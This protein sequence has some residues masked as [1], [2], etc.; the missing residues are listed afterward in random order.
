M[1]SAFA[2]AKPPGHR[3]RLLI[4]KTN[5][6]PGPGDL[7]V[8][9]A[10]LRQEM[11]A[12]RDALAT[13]ARAT[14]SGRLV[15]WLADLLA[16]KRITGETFAV[17]SAIGSEVDAERLAGVLRAA[18]LRTVYPRIVADTKVLDFC[19][20][21]DVSELE[22]GVLD[23]PAPKADAP[24]VDLDSIDVFV[25]PALAVAPDGHRL[26]YGGGYYDATL[27]AAPR[28]TRVG[29][30]YDVQILP[31]LPSGPGDAA[32]DWIVATDRGAVRAQPG[33]QT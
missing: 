6:M 31:G 29:A 14:A 26:G 24:A 7:R 16:D 9:K 22:P 1:E 33:R 3:L 25:V 8:E 5:P 10:K 2:V 17:Y 12:M 19:V 4:L 11:R 32:L 15:L 23:I 13:P 30:V 21:N 20:V 18:G 28:A 27:A